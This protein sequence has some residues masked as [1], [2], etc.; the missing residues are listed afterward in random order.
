MGYS[1]HACPCGFFGDEEKECNCSPLAIE[2]YRNRI[3]GPLWDRMDLQVMVYRPKYEQLRNSSLEKE[4]SSETVRERVIAA[5]ERQLRRS[6]W[7]NAHLDAE[8][9]KQVCHISD[10]AESLLE[11][12]YRRLNLSGRGLH[13]TLKVARTIADL[14]GSEQISETH[15]AEALQYRL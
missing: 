10:K 7:C 15:I 12:A 2:R 14:H 5:R 11:Q 3:S 4:E 1:L 8:M 6:P 13:R 9:M